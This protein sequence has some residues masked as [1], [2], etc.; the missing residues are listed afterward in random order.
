[1]RKPLILCIVFIVAAF[2]ALPKLL[3]LRQVDTGHLSW[4]PPADDLGWYYL[5]LVLEIGALATGIAFIWRFG[6]FVWR[7][8]AE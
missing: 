8:I 6:L 7:E 2:W 4:L 1:M 3:L 5:G